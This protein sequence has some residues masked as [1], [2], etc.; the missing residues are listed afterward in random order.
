MKP[1]D[2]DMQ[3]KRLEN[4]FGFKAMNYELKILAS[5]EV[6][7][8]DASDFREIINLWVGDLPHTKP[9]LL[10]EFRWAKS[11][12]QGK[13]RARNPEPAR[14]IEE[15]KCGSCNNV[16]SIQAIRK[17]E[18]G[19]RS[20]TYSFLCPNN[21]QSSNKLSYQIPRWS[22]KYEREFRRLGRNEEPMAAWLQEFP[23]PPKPDPDILEF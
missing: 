21:C 22:S 12:M 16:G 9:P 14:E 5:S 13:E 17:G 6:I 18:K 20:S 11:V 10:A 15:V 23:P 2:F 8:G 19:K 7:S 4:K 3:W 1:E